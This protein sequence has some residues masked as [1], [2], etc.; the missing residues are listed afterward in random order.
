DIFNADSEAAQM[1]GYLLEGKS[2]N[3]VAN[4]AMLRK[5]ILTE[6]KDLSEKLNELFMA[7]H[8]GDDRLAELKNI[9]EEEAKT[10][11][12][13]SRLP[14]SNRVT[15]LKAQIEAARSI[16]DGLHPSKKPDTFWTQVKGQLI[17]RTLEDRNRL[18]IEAKGQALQIIE[19]R[20]WWSDCISMS[21][22][23]QVAYRVLDKDG[24]ITK[25]GVILKS[26]KAEMTSFKEMPEFS[27][28]TP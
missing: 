24:K 2:P 14:D 12:Q 28:P 8:K 19:S 7:V 4:P 10:K 21:G 17:S 5:E 27:F 20:W 22:E 1:L 13:S 25:V 6:A 15:E 9:Q 16:L 3:F 26:S 23:I 11:P 18:L